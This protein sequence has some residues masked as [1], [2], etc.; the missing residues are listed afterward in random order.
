MIKANYKEALLEACS[1]LDLH[2]LAA[3]INRESP[4]MDPK[5]LQYS[6]SYGDPRN[7]TPNFGKPQL[8]CL[9]R[10]PGRIG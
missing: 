2:K 7:G 4:N 1:D 10:W 6:P 8:G 3:V 5:M 9:K